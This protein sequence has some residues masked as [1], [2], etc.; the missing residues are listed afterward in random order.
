DDKAARST[1]TVRVPVNGATG[2]TAE[3]AGKQRGWE[4][5]HWAVAH[6]VELRIE[7]VSYAGREWSATDSGHNWSEPKAGSG[8]DEVQIVTG[9]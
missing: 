7:R 4:L 3:G 5:A 8:S 2:V 6:A 1:R 9:Q